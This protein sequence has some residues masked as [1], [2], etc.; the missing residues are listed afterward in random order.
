MNEDL[1]KLQRSLEQ[2]TAPKPAPGDLDLQTKSLR[3]AWVA[4]G[5][6]L[7]TAQPRTTELSFPLPSNGTGANAA[8][9]RRRLLSAA[10]LLA[11]S[12]LIGIATAWMFRTT[13]N[14]PASPVVLAGQT[15]SVNTNRVTPAEK[16]RQAAATDPQWNDSLDE[17]IAQ[18]GQGVILAQQDQY[19]AAD[20]LGAVQYGI[21]RIQQ[22]VDGDKL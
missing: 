12:L 15:A 10:G 7:E 22:D 1:D 21:E 3:A 14:Q 18:V 8:R 17:Q 2:A 4:F 9:R 6:L 20:A 19:S 11:A 16:Q 5:Q 13:T